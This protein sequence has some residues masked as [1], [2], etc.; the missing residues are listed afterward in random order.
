MGMSREKLLEEGWYKNDGDL[1]HWHHEKFGHEPMSYD[2][3][4]A[5]LKN[6]TPEGIMDWNNQP[7][8]FYAQVLEGRY[9]FDSSGEA[10]AAHELIRFYRANKDRDPN[11]TE[12]EPL[13]KI[14]DHWE[15]L[16]AETRRVIAEG[17][18]MVSGLFTM[19]EANKW[20]KEHPLEE[21]LPEFNQVRIH[22]IEVIEVTNNPLI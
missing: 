8:E 17:T 20:M 22:N 13:Y 19:A 10:K 18:N 21:Q 3:A 14:E 15:R 2:E 6:D 16:N 11:R 12:N 7:M 4:C 5:T 1:V 9:R